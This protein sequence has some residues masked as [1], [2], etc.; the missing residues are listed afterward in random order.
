L[1]DL[2]VDVAEQHDLAAEHPQLA[3]E[4]QRKYELWSAQMQDPAWVREPGRR[5]ARRRA[6]P[7]PASRPSG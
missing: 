5:A 4:M 2:S 3:A 1:F 6:S 7:A